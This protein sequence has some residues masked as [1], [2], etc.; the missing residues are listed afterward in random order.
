MCE[1]HHYN[2]LII[3]LLH[4]IIIIFL[5]K[6]I[7]PQQ[8]GNKGNQLFIFL[9]LKTYTL[10]VFIIFHFIYKINEMGYKM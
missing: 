7:Y 1:Q 8:L 10:C 4:F 3:I 6:K 5:L 2:I 9:R